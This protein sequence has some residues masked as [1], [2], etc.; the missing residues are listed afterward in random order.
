VWTSAAAAR[1]RAT[2]SGGD[3]TFAVD[4]AVVRSV[5]TAGAQ[6]AQV[7]F[8]VFNLLEQPLRRHADDLVC[9]SRQLRARVQ[10]ERE[11]ELADRRAVRVV[12][13]GGRLRVLGY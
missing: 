12:G 13:V 4:F 3:D 5:A 9:D 11:P 2:A 7:R 1:S 6:R 8:E 10:H